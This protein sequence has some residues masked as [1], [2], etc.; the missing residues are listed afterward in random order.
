MESN[1]PA[2]DTAAG[3]NCY[4]KRKKYT[5]VNSLSKDMLFRPCILVFHSAQNG[6]AWDGAPSFFC[7]RNPGRKIIII[8]QTAAKNMPVSILLLNGAAAVT[9]LGSVRKPIIFSESGKTEYR[10]GAMQVYSRRQAERTG[11]KYPGLK[12]VH[13]ASDYRQISVCR[14]GS[15]MRP[16]EQTI[17]LISIL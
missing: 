1:R 17:T 14:Q 13:S 7:Q 16:Y 5:A 9:G 2:P 8:G 6:L 15:V 11:P 10:R 4:L 3:R 12:P